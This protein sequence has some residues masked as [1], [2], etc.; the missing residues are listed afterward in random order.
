MQDI[1]IIGSTGSIGTQAI[2]VVNEYGFSVVGLSC[3]SNIELFAA[4]CAQLKP[5][6]AGV[7]DSR[8]FDRAKQLIDVPHLICSENAHEE[9]LAQCGADTA[10]ISVVGFA[11]LRPL[12]RCIEMGIRACVA[13]KESIVC[14]GAAITRLLK[15]NNARIYPV[16]SEHSAIFQSLEGNEGREIRR[17]LLTCS[18]GPFRTWD[19]ADI[20]KA[21]YKQALKHPNWDMGNKITID[22]STYVNKGLEVL[23]AKWLFGVDIEQIEVLVHPQSIVHSMVEYV[24]GSVIGQLGVPDMKLPICFALAYPER[25]ARFDNTLELWKQPALEFEQP[26]TDKFPCLALAYEAGR[27][28]GGAPIA[29]NAANDV[30]VDAYINE[31][32]SFYDIPDIIEKTMQAVT[33]AREPE[34]AD[35]FDIDEQARAYALTCK[36]S[37]NL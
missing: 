19:K 21:N 23:E 28:G 6:Y 13:N 3:H 25:L 5:Q 27:T 15:Q 14:G 18:G 4:Q 24:D 22:S 1:C 33:F 11:G 10:L 2:D 30:A 20:A 12:I 16:D 37:L 8:Q 29:F 32:I 9:V 7:S 36:R 34:I 26:D 35:I 31:E 17:I